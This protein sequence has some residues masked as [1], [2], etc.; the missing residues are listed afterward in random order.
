[1]FEFIT[2]K[3]TYQLLI[4]TIN[5]EAQPPNTNAHPHLRLKLLRRSHIPPNPSLHGHSPTRIFHGGWKQP[6]HTNPRNNFN[7][8]RSCLLRILIPTPH[9]LNKI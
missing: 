2:Y 3:L 4:F 1:V 7:S 6:S 8:L 5:N 9:P